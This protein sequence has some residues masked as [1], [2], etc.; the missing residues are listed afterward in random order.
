MI[1]SST[2]VCMCIRAYIL[3]VGY[4]RDIH[5]ADQQEGKDQDFAYLTTTLQ[6]II[7]VYYFE[8][9]CCKRSVVSALS[10]SLL[11]E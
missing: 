3:V 9:Y 10:S 1:S 6:I 4:L 11:L 8:I 7:Y 5:G 2:Y